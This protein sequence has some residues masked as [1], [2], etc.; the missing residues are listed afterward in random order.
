MSK[1]SD[2]VLK[3]GSMIVQGIG[4]IIG[5]L[6]AIGAYQAYNESKFAS[7]DALASE[8]KQR[9]SE[10]SALREDIGDTQDR[11]DNLFIIMSGESRPLKKVKRR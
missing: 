4:A 6:M 3:V 1:T 5:A 2:A 11:I 8:S 7:K 9:A 10:Y